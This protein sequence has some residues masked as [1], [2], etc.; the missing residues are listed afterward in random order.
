MIRRPR[1]RTAVIPVGSASVTQSTTASIMI[2]R[3]DCPVASS[4]PMRGASPIAAARTTA[5]TAPTD[6]F[7]S[8]GMLAADD[9]RV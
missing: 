6:C 3:A 4:C 1:A 5:A 7:E 2:A 9:T 8:R